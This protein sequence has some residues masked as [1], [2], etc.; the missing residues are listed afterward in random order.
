MYVRWVVSGRRTHAEAM[1]ALNTFIEAIIDR[2]GF[3]LQVQKTANLQPGRAVHR[4]A[5]DSRPRPLPGLTGGRAAALPPA[6][7]GSPLSPRTEILGE[8]LIYT[9]LY[10]TKHATAAWAMLY[11]TILYKPCYSCLGYTVLHYT[12][13]NM[14]QLPGLCC[15]ILYYTILYRLQRPGL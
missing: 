3:Q 5:R 7:Q 13:Q 11:Y 8:A 2:C 12:K 4:A 1:A 14:L 10:Y 15:T 6:I 9:T